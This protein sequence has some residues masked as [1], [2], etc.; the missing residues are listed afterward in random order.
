MNKTVMT[1]P[2]T[3]LHLNLDLYLFHKCGSLATW[4]LLTFMLMR[5]LKAFSDTVQGL[6]GKESEQISVEKTSFYNVIFLKSGGQH[7]H[8]YIK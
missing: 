2:S 7:V 3:P 5:K 4:L 6:S 8:I 1:P